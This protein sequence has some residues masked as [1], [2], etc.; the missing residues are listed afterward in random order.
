[1]NRP[2]EERLARALDRVHG[3]GPPDAYIEDDAEVLALLET[4]GYLREN[5]T[6]V[7]APS[8]FRSELRDWLGQ[9]RR[10]PWW[11]WLMEPARRHIPRSARRPALGAAIG[12]GAAAAIVVGV[13]ALRRR[14]LASA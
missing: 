11:Q 8:S 12:V 10:A 1:M 2:A 14:R 9:P 13:V 7:P 6:R 4:A 5:L 3:G